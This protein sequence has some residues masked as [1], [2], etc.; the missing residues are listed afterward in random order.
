[1]KYTIVLYG[2]FD[3]YNYGDNLMPILFEMYMVKNH[4][5]IEQRANFIYASIQD[6]D[7]SCYGCKPTIAMNRLLDIPSGSTVVVVGGEVLGAN[8][9]TLYTHVQ[10]S[11]LVTQALRFIRKLSPSLLNRIALRRYKAVWEYPYIP[12]IKDFENKIKVIYNTVGGNPINAQRENVISATYV[13]AR[14]NRTYNNLKEFS[15]PVLVPDSVLMA[16]T[17]IDDSF[18]D[19]VVRHEV[20]QIVANDFISIQAC[21]YK[22]NFSATQLASELE[23]VSSKYSLKVVLLPIGYASG[24]DDVVF[25]QKVNACANNN[26]ILLDDLNVWEIMYIISKSKVFYGTSLH[27][28]ITAMSFCVP[29]YSINSGIEKLTSF[30]Q[31]WSIYPYNTPI[32]IDK[33]SESIESSRCEGVNNLERATKN[34]Q[35]IIRASLDDIAAIL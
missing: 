3:R 12:D 31:T 32:T 35:S 10:N 23:T 11:L 14:D 28:V 33:I 6:S 25:L 18:F 4:P 22:V 34:A 7:L 27:G 21:P 5:D 8:V 9:G 1:M 26:F 13:S 17:I 29:H 19:S 15:Q 24:H 16:S 20:R 2:A 30:L